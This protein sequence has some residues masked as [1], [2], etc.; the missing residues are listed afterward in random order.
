MI[1]QQEKVESKLLDPAEPVRRRGAANQSDPSVMKEDCSDDDNGE[2]MSKEQ[3][4]G[5]CISIV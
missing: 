3:T 5:T 1:G 4:Y 2:W